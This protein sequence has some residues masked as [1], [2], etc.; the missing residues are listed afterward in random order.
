MSK[1]K[2]GAS[3]PSGTRTSGG[4]KSK[5]PAPAKLPAT[6][7]KPKPAGTGTS[8]EAST[9]A[10]AE[11]DG[12]AAGRK[13]PKG[14]PS[15]ADLRRY[16]AKLLET[17]GNLRASSSDLATEALKSSGQ[18]FSVDHMA[19]HGSDNYEQDFSL[20]LLEGEAEQLRDVREALLKIDGKMDLPF[21]LCEACSDD[22]ALKCET[23]PWIPP[24]RL[25]AVPHARLCV[26]M[27][28]QEERRKT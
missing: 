6:P 23:C 10:K 11:K 7:A 25:D 17:L 26:Q 16:R 22:P 1:S 21:G 4:S 24:S 8:A 18:D 15:R 19:D 12:A 3:T 9:G 14:G 13:W 5:K 27:Q 28:E 20:S 2:K